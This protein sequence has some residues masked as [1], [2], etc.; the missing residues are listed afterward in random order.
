M[1]Y[2]R[3]RYG[4]AI[5]PQSEALRIW[6]YLTENKLVTEIEGDPTPDMDLDLINV[7]VIV[8]NKKRFED[9]YLKRQ[10]S[11]SPEDPR[12]LIVGNPVKLQDIGNFP[13]RS[14]RKPKNTS[15]DDL[16]SKF[17]IREKR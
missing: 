6:N 8:P 2:G 7:V 12:D 5:K 13:V 4:I 3:H 11:R 1:A 15:F 17:D 10:E 14:R 9:W 16:K